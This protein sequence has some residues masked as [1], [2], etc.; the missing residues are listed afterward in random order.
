MTDAAK[1]LKVGDT[2]SGYRLLRIQQLDLIKSTFFEFIHEKT[3][4][5][6]IHIKSRDRENVFG[7]A[8]K[9][10]PKDSTGVAHILEHTALCGSAKYPVRDPF[11]S[12]I[13]RSLN[14]FMNA[15]T[16]SDWTMYPFASQNDKDYYN[17]MG[18]YLDAAFFPNL[19]ELSFMQEGHR[20]SVD[21]KGDLSYQGVVFNEMKGA[22]S[23]Q[24]QVMGRSLLN[25]LY[26]DTTYAN[27]SGGEPSDIPGL[28][29]DDLV[30][31][32][33]V[34][35]HPS[36]SYFFTY[37]DLCIEKHL[38]YI[39]KNVLDK[40]T[41]IDPGTDVPCQERW[42]KPGEAVYTYAADGES[43]IEKKFQFAVAWLTSDIQ[44]SFDTLV[45]ALL[46]QILFGNSAAPLYK[47]LIDSGLG[48]SLSDVC[49]FDADNR[50]TLF[51]A[52]LKNIKEEDAHKVEKI[53]L[54]TFND[55][56]AKGIEKE[57]IETAIHQFEFHRR[58]VSNTPM[59]YGLK[60]FLNI[61]STWF[62]GGDPLGVILFDSDLEKIR[63]ESIDGR[64]FETYIQ[65]YFLENT[66]RVS[67][68]LKPDAGENKEKAEK[69]K[70]ELDEKRKSLTD[71]DLEKIKSLEKEL[72]LLQ[73]NKEDLSCLPSLEISDVSKDIKTE[74]PNKIEDEKIFYYDKPTSEIFYFTSVFGAGNLDSD[75]L[76]YV[77]IF[78]FLISKTGTGKRDYVEF[79]RKVDSVTG[80]FGF[81]PQ[82]R[83]FVFDSGIVSPS[84]IFSAKC[85]ER[86]QSEMFS[87]A[88]EIVSDYSFEDTD[89]II[90]LLMQFRSGLESGI[91]QNGHRL[92]ISLASRNI[93]E[94]SNLSE[95]WFG[96]HQLKLVKELTDKFNDPSI[97]DKAIED[98]KE[99]MNSIGRTIFNSENYNACLVGG[100]SNLLKG[101]ELLP[102]FSESLLK[103]GDNGF[104]FT[105]NLRSG[106]KKIR[107][108][109]TTQSSVSFVGGCFKGPEYDSVESP[110]FSV[111][112]RLLKSN[113]LHREI[114]EK[115]GAYGGLSLYNS[116][117]GIFS[118]VSY[119]DPH[120]SRT[121]GIFGD[122]AEYLKKGNFSEEEIKEAVLQTA[123]D[124][125]RPDTPA[126][127]AKKDFFRR[128]INLSDE[129]RRKFKEGV[130]SL[131]GEKLKKTAEKYF[132]KSVFDENLAVITG[133]VPF[134]KEKSL[135]K[136]DSL[137][138]N[139]I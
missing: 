56:V 107:E 82:V 59:P 47:A 102:L 134:E 127:S 108:A 67:L 29:H 83:T 93:S 91:V 1:E 14:T 130:L 34:H 111:L 32:H 131:D 49:G 54:D 63:N 76:A 23:S 94:P 105:G 17:L 51:A 35:Y 39:E 36:N 58:E 129:E 137:M 15:F 86:Y 46:D 30:N 68:L 136:E 3:K 115:G 11:F 5:R 139:K 74:V 21:E 22:M 124:L 95:I 132:D 99:K 64:L 117:E 69:E 87:L 89:R 38:E 12:M 120:I 41:A 20:L 78:S 114:R 73:E 57:L 66:H 60:M 42:E 16:A 128:L 71:A 106:I 27:N 52:G 26:P 70:L 4:A 61:A 84:I 133:Q 85:L 28:T 104:R 53:V 18:I 79:T 33:K 90:S 37:G 40:F 103:N 135:F 126:V 77:P 110:H 7:V 121:I 101:E 75:L 9:T 100:E 25:A 81:S 31:F 138:E 80:G 50:D 13:K 19:D 88:S 123:S 109:W 97:K 72:N 8:F 2:L 98:F 113:Y 65:K 62:H 92:A 116:E 119:R 6:H 55:L 112:A 45:L 118:C 24:S 96:I 44:N 10:V 125:E 43:D 122:G 48:S